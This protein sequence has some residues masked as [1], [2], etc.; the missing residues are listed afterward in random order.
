MGILIYREEWTQFATSG[1]ERKGH[2]PTGLWR[3]L[4]RAGIGILDRPHDEGANGC[5]GTAGALF[6]P[7]MQRFRE[8]DCGSGW[9]ELIMPQMRI[10]LTPQALDLRTWVGFAFSWP[11]LS[12][13]F[14]AAFV[15]RRQAM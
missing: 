1:D 13:Q 10:G 8:F 3:R 12:S 15:P 6:Q 4:L 9:H 14:L 11:T 5:A 7:V 2:S